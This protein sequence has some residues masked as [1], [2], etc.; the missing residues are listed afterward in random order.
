MI[1]LVINISLKNEN[2]CSFPIRPFC[3][4]HR[5]KTKHLPATRSQYPKKNS[6][7]GWLTCWEHN[8]S[9]KEQVGEVAGGAAAAVEQQAPKQATAVDN[10]ESASRI[11]RNIFMQHGKYGGTIIMMVRVVLVLPRTTRSTSRG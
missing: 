4:F 11:P 5:L 6:D 9:D 10:N 2:P 1:C 3:C 7:N 8:E